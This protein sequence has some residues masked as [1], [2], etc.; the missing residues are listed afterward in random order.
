MIKYP[1]IINKKNS[2][3][4][5]EDFLPATMELIKMKKE[6]VFNMTNP[7]TMDHKAIMKLYQKIVDPKFKLNFMSEKEEEKLCER[8]SNCVLSSEKREKAGAHMPALEESLVT[9][10]TN[11]KKA[12]LEE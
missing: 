11:Y 9:I 2:C 5:I 4:V 3:T 10:L 1:K 8:R 6:G 12:L 7:G